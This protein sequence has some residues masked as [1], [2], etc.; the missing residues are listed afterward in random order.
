MAYGGSILDAYFVCVNMLQW[1]NAL[2]NAFIEFLAPAN[3]C[4]DTKIF[5][6]RWLLP[7][8]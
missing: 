8:T 3:M 5:I 4:V 2:N 7:E 6:L 1:F